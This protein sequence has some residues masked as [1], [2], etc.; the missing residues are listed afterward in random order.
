MKKE[1]GND[2]QFLILM[3]FMLAFVVIVAIADDRNFRDTVHELRKEVRSL[4]KI[5]DG[6][7]D[8]FTAIDEAQKLTPR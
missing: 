4:N 3:L 5:I 1:K 6:Y 2:L 7:Q 8:Y